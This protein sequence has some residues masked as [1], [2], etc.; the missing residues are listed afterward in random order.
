MIEQEEGRHAWRAT[1]VTVVIRE[2]E[3]LMRIFNLSPAGARRVAAVRT[4]RERPGGAGRYCPAS[5]VLA[6][7]VVRQ[8]DVVGEIARVVRRSAIHVD[9]EAND[10]AVERMPRAIEDVVLDH[11]KILKL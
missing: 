2:R 8:V 9:E 7:R 10:E 1:V 6:A 5:G 3:P 11:V 4:G